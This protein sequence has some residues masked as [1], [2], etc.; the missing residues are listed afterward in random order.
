MALRITRPFANEAEFLA[1]EGATIGRGTLLLIGAPSQPVGVIVRFELALTDGVVLLRGEGKVVDRRTYRGDGSLIVKLTKLDAPS[2]Q[3]LDRVLKQREE[4]QRALVRE[5][6]ESVPP[7]GVETTGNDTATN[8]SGEPASERTAVSIDAE[9]AGVSERERPTIENL[10]RAAADAATETPIE[11]HFEKQPNEASGQRKTLE[12]LLAPKQRDDSI[13]SVHPTDASNSTTDAPF[14]IRASQETEAKRS[15]AALIEQAS[16]RAT[17]DDEVVS[18]NPRTPRSNRAA[19]IATVFEGTSSLESEA[20][21]QTASNESKKSTRFTAES[22]PTSNAPD[23]DSSATSIPEEH[24]SGPRDIPS[25]QRS[26]EPGISVGPEV[27]P[28][29]FRRAV[30]AQLETLR[31]R[32]RTGQGHYQARSPESQEAL[33]RLKQRGAS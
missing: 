5:G 7:K 23:V 19:P 16:V 14:E 18:D 29:S 8:N 31:K 13:T 22:S 10:S 27:E 17:I 15:E 9:I 33:R 26:E 21:A 3:F 12:S 24:P 6:S 4:A 2:K 32:A 30:H 25:T 20:S 1:K 11:K 28:P